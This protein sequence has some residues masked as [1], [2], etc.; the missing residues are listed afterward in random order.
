M[1]PIF[2]ATAAL[3]IAS[4]AT[5]AFA[6]SGEQ[7]FRT[8]LEGLLAPQT[9]QRGAA[10]QQAQPAAR[11]DVTDIN[12]RAAC[13]LILTGAGDQGTVQPQAGC[14]G[15][16]ATAASWRRADTDLELRN[17]ANQLVWRG[18]PNPAGEG[19]AGG[20]ADTLRVYAV[21]P[22]AAIQAGPGRNQT[23]PAA[24]V[25]DANTI[26]GDWRVAEPGQTR[27]CRL[28]FVRPDPNN[29]F[30][31]Q[32]AVRVERGCPAFVGSATQWFEANGTLTLADQAGQVQATLTRNSVDRWIGTSD[33]IQINLTRL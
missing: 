6:Q 8:L 29:R 31:Q 4:A 12:G 22:G 33:D 10:Q 24:P 16:L 7:V 17:A 15:A 19:W 13:S 32:N 3:A 20:A 25:F 23:A 21:E 5:P 14:P 30:A 18:Q 2:V 9:A 26:Y 27:G 1:R 28:T 11:F